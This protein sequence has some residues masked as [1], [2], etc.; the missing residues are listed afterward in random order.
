VARMS[1][2][3]RELALRS[4]KV[5]Q[6]ALEVCLRS[7]SYR[8]GMKYAVQYTHLSATFTASFIMRLARLFPD[9]CDLPSIMADVEE[10]VEILSEIPATR[11]ARTLKLMLRSAKRRRV[12][13]SRTVSDHT[14][15]APPRSNTTPTASQPPPP[16]SLMGPPQIGPVMMTPGGPVPP[17]LSIE[18]LDQFVRDYESMPGQDIPVWLSES[19]LG[20]LALSQ[21]G[22]EAFL[23]PPSLDD[24]RMVPE[25]W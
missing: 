3:Q 18:Q 20:D 25:I 8:E 11:F 17:S 23:I 21:Q 12:L 2:D 24:Q 13:P 1:E 6:D 9:D 5:A 15:S 22:L 19:N 14:G 16:S 4:M 10:L 7:P